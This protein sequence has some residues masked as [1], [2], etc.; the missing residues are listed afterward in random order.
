M[1]RMTRTLL[2]GAVTLCAFAPGFGCAEERDP[3]SHVQPNALPKTFFLGADLKSPQDDPSFYARTTIVDVGFGATQQ[4]LF[5]GNPSQ[6]SIIKWEIAEDQLIGRLAYEQVASDFRM[7]P[8][9]TTPV[10]V[11]YTGLDPHLQ[12]EAG[13][14]GTDHV[15]RL[16]ALLDEIAAL[17]HY[18]AGFGASRRLWQRAQPYLVSV[19]SRDLKQA[20][21]EG[22]V[23]DLGNGFWI[24]EG[25]YDPVRGLTSQRNA[26]D[27]VV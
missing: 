4:D 15:A 5:V 9:D 3:I 24:W 22:N 18:P 27:F 25:G 23:R 10:L 6:L 12:A 8:E 16:A 20:E 17:R 2:L 19:R 21:A 26:E 13:L 11:R 7:I 14:H 1:R